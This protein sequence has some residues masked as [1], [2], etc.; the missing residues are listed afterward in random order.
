MSGRGSAITGVILVAGALLLSVPSVASPAGAGGRAKTHRVSLG[1]HGRQ[2]DGAS[3][4]PAV[5]AHGRFVAFES[6]AS[7]LVGGD[8]NGSFDV[9]GRDRR[10]GKTKRLSVN[11]SGRQGNGQSRLPT[12]SSH[13]RFIAFWSDASNLVGGDT[14]HNSDVF[15]HDR[16]T[17]KTRRVS[18][19]SSGGQGNGDS[20]NPFM[21]AGGRFVSFES[22]A[23]NLVGGDSN[24]ARDV[25]V[26]DRRTGKTSRVSVSSS[27][28][29]VSGDSYDPVISPHGRLLA[30][31]S[32]APDLVRSDTNGASDVF[33]HDRKTGRTTRVS[34][35]S[36]G[37]Q[38]NGASL[39]AELSA[40]GRIVAF[41]SL[42]SNLVGGDTNGMSDLFVRNRRTKRTKRVSVSSSGAQANGL[43]RRSGP[44][45]GRFVAFHSLASNL[46]DGDR[47]DAFD[48]FVYDR[49]RGRTTRVSV[50]M[51][52]RPSNGLSGGPR[53]SADGRFAAFASRA[54][55]LVAGD[56][57]GNN[58]VFVRGPL[59]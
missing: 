56:T 38:G 3:G 9:F 34:V 53:L 30:F 41:T 46:V 5:S 37:G 51:A 17:G 35:D 10:T 42:A 8:T 44:T 22:S 25:F 55:N 23:S 26:H 57:N 16:R 13:A 4:E 31:S 43:S 6:S 33:L 58:D 40:R 14:N 2:A 29:Q 18:V 45:V 27:R 28:R 48:V 47:N 50:G 15:V 21:S 32:D 39:E 52:G 12:L 54:S 59:L 20:V 49:G 11:G 24:G 1:A 7:N 19:R 36:S